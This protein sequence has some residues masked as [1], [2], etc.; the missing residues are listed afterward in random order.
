[1][2]WF[3]TMT[4]RDSENTGFG[5]GHSLSAFEFLGS[6]LVLTAPKVEAL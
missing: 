5:S 3:E 4:F 2:R 1:M 6:S